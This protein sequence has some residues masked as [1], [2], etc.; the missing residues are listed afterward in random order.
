VGGARF[1][2]KDVPMTQVKRAIFVHGEGPTALVRLTNMSE[3]H[4]RE[5]MVKVGVGGTDLRYRPQYDEWSAT[6]EITFTPTLIDAASVLALIDAGGSGDGVGE[7]RPEKGGTF[8]TYAVDDSAE[9]GF[10][11]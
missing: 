9:I 7:W 5:D 1:Y 8:G 3:A 6:L 4:M 10:V 11:G 2:G